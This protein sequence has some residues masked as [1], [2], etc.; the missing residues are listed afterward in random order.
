LSPLLLISLALADDVFVDAPDLVEEPFEKPEAELAAELG[1]AWS[2]GNTDTRTVTTSYSAAYRFHRNQISSKGGL[3]L[4]SAKLDAD[5]DGTL[6]ELERE[7]DRVETARKAQALVRYDRFMTERGSL[8]SLAGA[9]TDPYA[10]YD[11]R[12]NAQ[13]G[14][15]HLVFAKRDGPEQEL[16]ITLVHAE[17]GFDLAREDYAEGVEPEIA[18]K[19]SARAGLTLQ[20]RI[21]PGLT[22]TDELEVFVNV[23]DPG[24]TRLVNALGLSNQLSEQM[25]VKLSYKL[26]HDTDPVE[27][28]VK[29]DHVGLVTLVATVF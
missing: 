2:A 5:G 18:W 23:R 29:A 26:A 27:G 3:I 10:G 8:Y 7:A 20:Q 14:Y 17:L 11:S 24:D 1:G 22:L 16:A 9:Y 12:Y 28:Y 15:S 25:S 6:S 13:W 4:G 19:P 21:T